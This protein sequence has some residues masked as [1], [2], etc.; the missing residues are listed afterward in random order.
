M[1]LTQARIRVIFRWVHIVLGLL[2]L[3]YVYSPFSSYLPFRLFIK[4]VAIPI[5]VL[6][7]LWLWKFAFFNRL[8]GIK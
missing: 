6:S 8:L 1:A 3:C 2:L 7:G 5:I 4:I